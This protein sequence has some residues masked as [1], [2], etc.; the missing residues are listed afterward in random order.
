VYS[1][2][3]SGIFSIGDAE[4]NLPLHQDVRQAVVNDLAAGRANDV[5]DEKYPQNRPF[6]AKIESVGSRC[7]LGIAMRVMS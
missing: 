7:S 3:G 2:T 6:L 4:I 1:K 5:S